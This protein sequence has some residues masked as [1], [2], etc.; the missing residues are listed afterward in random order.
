MLLHIRKSHAET[1]AILKQHQFKLGGIAHAFSGGIE[2]AKAFIKWV[3][4]K[5]VSPGQITNPNEKNYMR[6]FRKSGLNIWSW[7]QIVQ[8]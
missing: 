5:L 2:E 6:W 3:G 7:K 1:L 8:I 4:L